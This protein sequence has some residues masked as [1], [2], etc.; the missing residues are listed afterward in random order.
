MCGRPAA[1]NHSYPSWIEMVGFAFE[2]RDAGCN[3]SSSQ[4][5]SAVEAQSVCG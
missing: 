3:E 5:V 4:R 2:E 1:D